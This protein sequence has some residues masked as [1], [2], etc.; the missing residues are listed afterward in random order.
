M[1]GALRRRPFDC[2]HLELNDYFAQYAWASHK[3]DSATTTVAMDDEAVAGFVTFV[4]SEID[5]KRWREPVLRI[6]RFGIDLKYQRRGIGG[7]LVLHCLEAAIG[8]RTYGGCV[9]LVVDAKRDTNAAAY[10]ARF[11]FEA[12][13][14]GDAR[15]IPMFLPM[16]T[17]I[18]AVEAAKASH[19]RT[20]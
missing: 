12:M 9:G 1:T 2:G 5:G 18:A 14:E 13:A 11:G 6:C 3:R 8:K 16:A 7:I 10:Y 19:A 15:T 4:G 20:P 17:V